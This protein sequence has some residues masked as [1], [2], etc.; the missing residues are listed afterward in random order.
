[1]AG[2]HGARRSRRGPELRRGVEPGHGRRPRGI[3]DAPVTAV[4]DRPKPPD[5]R[6]PAPAP[7]APGAANR[8]AHRPSPFLVVGA[9]VAL[10]A[11]TAAAALGLDRVFA[12]GDFVGPVLLAAIGG[13]GVA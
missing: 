2:A 10:V 1:S 9:E 12:D 11:V 4:L 5:G 8:A 13:H 6:S 3:G 7:T